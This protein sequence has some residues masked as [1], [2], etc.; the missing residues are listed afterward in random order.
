MFDGYT[1]LCS[2]ASATPNPPHPLCIYAA[3]G[4][5]R[6]L[7]LNSGKQLKKLTNLGDVEKRLKIW[8]LL[9]IFLL[10]ILT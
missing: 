7:W 3:L 6:S 5:L 4:K 2:R 10:F 8:A 1:R 9:P